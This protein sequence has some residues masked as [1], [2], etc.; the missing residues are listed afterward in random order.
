M[1]KFK[2]LQNK[3]ELNQKQ[4]NEIKDLQNEKTNLIALKSELSA[5]NESLQKIIRF[6]ERR[7]CKNSGR[8]KTTIRE[9]G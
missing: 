1:L 5:Q 9:F 6:S 7:N 8:S 3:T 2:K 4:N